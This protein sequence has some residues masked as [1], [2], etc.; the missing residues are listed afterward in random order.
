MDTH[1]WNSPLL[2]ATHSIG[3]QVI[4]RTFSL[5]VVSKPYARI[6]CPLVLALPFE[7]TQNKFT[8]FF[9]SACSYPIILNC[10]SSR[11]MSGILLPFLQAELPDP[12]SDRYI[13]WV[14][15]PYLV[16]G[17][18]TPQT[19]PTLSGS[20]GCLLQRPTSEIQPEAC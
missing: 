4:I 12:S 19:V 10:L 9:L 14:Y 3:S 5:T 16:L 17:T 11:Q 8:H 2:E 1:G 20:E 18:P 7:D 15:G 13:S 6:F